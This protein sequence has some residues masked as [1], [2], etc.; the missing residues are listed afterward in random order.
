MDGAVSVIIDEVF[1]CSGVT[2][3]VKVVGISFFVEVLV[4]SFLPV[5]MYLWI[6]A[7]NPMAN[8][9]Y[10][11]RI[12]ALAL[13]GNSYREPDERESHPELKEQIEYDYF[14]ENFP[15][16]LGIISDMIIRL[17]FCGSPQSTLLE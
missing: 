12:S 10:T 6:L 11:E 1:F 16:D 13:Q 15:D 8:P 7:N 5:F 9:S 3:T 14:E 2:N 4:L 17:P